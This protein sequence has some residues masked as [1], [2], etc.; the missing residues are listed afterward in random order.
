MPMDLTGMD[1][2]LAKIK[3]LGMNVE[4]AKYKA[5]DVGGGVIAA[6]MV[7]RAPFREKDRS[8]WQFRAGKRYGTEH[9]KHSI[10]VEHNGAQNEYVLVGPD[11]EFFYARFY[12]FG[13]VNQRARPFLEP[14]YLSKRQECLDAIAQKIKEAIEGA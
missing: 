4:R 9:M 5:L 1:E 14:A 2:M 10:G 11:A 13:T 8:R 12:E 7:A 6:E 3:K